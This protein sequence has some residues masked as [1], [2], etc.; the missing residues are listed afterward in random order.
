MVIYFTVI[1]GILLMIYAIWLWKKL[2][3]EIR[4]SKA[5]RLWL[6]I[7]ALICFFLFG[8]IIYF[9]IR[10][11][12]YDAISDILVGFIMLFGAMFVVLI[13][14]LNFRSTVMLN[15]YVRKLEGET[16]RTNEINDRLKKNEK[17]L[18]GLKNE[19]EQRNIE[20]LET[21]DDFYTM[22]ISLQEE[23]KTGTIEKENIK[24]KKRLD[25]LKN[26]QNK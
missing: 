4:D 20:L 1:I 17:E 22:R 18:K 15:S 13:L 25:S 26:N 7:L 19:I 11:L 21:M 16:K 6:I 14:K 10:L 23:M 9:L 3:S 5:R 12:D 8:Y 2:Y 24:I